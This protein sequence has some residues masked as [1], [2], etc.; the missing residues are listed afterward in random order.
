MHHFKRVLA[1]GLM[2]L[3]IFGCVLSAFAEE[4]KPDDKWFEE[5]LLTELPSDEKDVISE[6][7]PLEEPEIKEY[8]DKYIVLAEPCENLNPNTVYTATVNLFQVTVDEET[9][10]KLDR[11]YPLAIEDPNQKRDEEHALPENDDELTAPTN[12]ELEEL[13]D[14][15]GWCDHG[16]TELDLDKV[17]FDV[18]VYKDDEDVVR[19]RVTFKA[20]KV[21]EAVTKVRRSAHRAASLVKLKTEYTLIPED[22]DYTLTHVVLH[23]VTPEYLTVVYKDGLNGEVFASEVYYVAPRSW[24]PGSKID[25]LDPASVRRGYIFAGWDPERTQY[26]EKDVTYTAIWDIATYTITYEGI[27]EGVENPN[28]STY[29]IQDEVVLNDL[30]VDGFVCWLDEDG[31]EITSIPADSIGD[32]VLTAKIIEKPV[33]PR[34]GTNVSENLLKIQC[35]THEEHSW[36]NSSAFSTNARDVK[37]NA[38]TKRWESHVSVS[39]NQINLTQIKKNFFGGITHYY[40]KNNHAVNVYFDP[41]AQ[42][43]TS[44]GNP[45]TGMW[46]AVDGNPVV[47]DVECYDVPAAPKTVT[48]KLWIRDWT[49]LANWERTTKLIDGTYT[50]SGVY[51]DRT[52]G[53]F[54]DVTINDLSAY[55]SA[56]MAA[57]TTG[58]YIVDPVQN[59]ATITYR[60]KYTGS[61]T[62][63]KQDGSGWSIYTDEWTATDKNNGKTI[64]VL[65][66]WTTTYT[67]GLD[68]EAFAD[69]VIVYPETSNDVAQD[70]LKTGSIATPPFGESP[71]RAGYAFQGW[72]PEVSEELLDNVTYTAK[73][74]QNPAVPSGSNSQKELFKFHCT[75][76]DGHADQ[77]YNWFGSYVKYNGDMAYD[78]ARGVFTA[79]A[80]ITNVQTLLSTGVKAPEK[81]WGMKHYHTDD[82]GNTVRTAT[83]HLVWDANATGLNASGAETTGLWVPDGEQLVNVWCATEPAAPKLTMLT[84]RSQQ[85]ATAIRVLSVDEPLGTRATNHNIPTYFKYLTAGSY[86]MSPVTKDTN[87]DFWVTL[88]IDPSS[89]LAAFNSKNSSEPA[90]RVDTEK[91]IANFTYILKYVG[92][93][94]NYAQDGSGWTVDSSSYQ[95]VDGDSTKYGKILYVTNKYQVTYTDGVEEAEVFPD[96]VYTV[97]S[98]SA[99]PAFDGTPEREGYTFAGWDPEITETV[100][101][102]VTYT[103]KWVRT[104][105]VPSG[106][107]SQKELF[108]FHCTVNDGHADQTYNWFGSYV[109]YN[110]DMVYDAARG[111][112]TAT[113]NITNVQTLLSTGVK[114]PEKVWG[115][116]H[117]HTDDAGNTVRTATIH[118][119][120]DANATGL[121]ASGAETTGLWVPDGEQLV[122]VWCATEPAAPKLTMLTPRSQQ[123]ATAIRVLSVD[124]PLGTRATNHNIPT[125]FKYLTAGSY[126]MSPVT[127][128]TNGDFWVTLV[129][130][131]SSYLAAFN[132]KNSS[133]PAYRVDT[134]K[135]TTD[136]T[137]K[138]RYAGSKTNYAQDGSG[139]TVDSSSY[140][141]GESAKYSKILYVTNKYQVTYTDGVEEAEVFPDQVYTVLSGSAT[142]AFD[143]TPG[144]EGYTFV[145]WDPEVAETVTADAT[146]TAQWARTYSITYVGVPEGVENPN[147]ATYTEKGLALSDLAVDGFLGWAD[148]EG[149]VLTAIPAGTTGDLVLTVRI[150][151]KPAMPEIGANVTA[152]LLK[153]QCTTHE[154]HSWT[155]SSAFNTSEQFITWNAAAKRWE[156]HVLVTLDQ[157]NTTRIRDNCFDGITHFYAVNEPAVNVYFVPDAQSTASAGSTVTGLWYAASG[158]PAVLDVTCY[159]APAAPSSIETCLCIQDWTNLGNWERITTAIDGTYTVSDVYGDRDSG[160]YVDVTITNLSAYI[161]S[162]MQAKSTGHYILDP[163]QN[164][165]VIS[166]RM[167]YTGSVTDLK[168]DG[169]GWSV[170]TDEWGNRESVIGKIIWVLPQWIT[171]YKD[172]ADGAVFADKSIVF[173]QTS[174]DVAQNALASGTLMTPSFGEDPVREGYTFEGW[175]PEVAGSLTASATYTATWAEVDTVDP[176][177]PVDP[178][179]SVDPTDSVDPTEPVDPTDPAD[180]MDPV[181]PTD[182]VDPSE[183]TNPVESGKEDEIPDQSGEG[184]QTPAV[185]GKD[186]EDHPVVPVPAPSVEEPA[187]DPE[188]ENS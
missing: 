154:E 17:K 32:R 166:Y 91:T 87:G 24:T 55:I 148:S 97:L 42:G 16:E 23:F 110:G 92:N 124:E 175:T 27:P 59:G 72:E 8:A 6:F 101:V 41:N 104:P 34:I 174:N 138:L 28:P 67:D 63:L 169:S 37:W 60:M 80:N 76:N 116:K 15:K 83:I 115:M 99:T 88:T 79:T 29:T 135:T 139:W 184:E 140:L 35:I 132:S 78:A 118:L 38:E 183:S 127:K 11:E 123:S 162:S 21:A 71:V 171:T 172:G 120:W 51:G 156:S 114:A 9:V 128:D 57:K 126:T 61:L 69:K 167:R 95:K 50:V 22:E 58:T 100:T 146:Y 86:T 185:P 153:I 180:S 125:Y 7:V 70:V 54:V 105:A 65:P 182:S 13:I 20:S 108:K 64:W 12:E 149:N 177:D 66:Q 159:D 36:T 75:V 2:L 168:Q 155:N 30:D 142:P 137:Y 18:V 151:A 10:W 93:E 45:V 107:N 84:P 152:D 165:S 111:V 103:A 143:G 46:F 47:L 96:Q 122:N 157:I 1:S 178:T 82:A 62:D 109:K 186:E 129:I 188:K 3:V 39:L 181:N 94:T 131:P 19:A 117:Y 134:E 73:W 144:R 53:F 98:G 163:V 112:F 68:G 136:F 179:E 44:L 113:A 106:S 85:S 133:E 52:D 119:V 187:P 77:T 102:D 90:Y 26:V 25:S 89:Y 147:P 33:Q 43:T 170:Y 130:D 141:A 48:T 14:V 173:P 145:G 150:I 160:F 176:T 161:S 56:K 4:Q 121:N 5:H 40:E 74:I 164:G 49:K 81:V 158:N 31:Q